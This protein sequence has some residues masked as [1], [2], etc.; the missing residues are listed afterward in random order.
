[1]S[2]VFYVATC[3]VCGEPCQGYEFRGR[4]RVEM[5]MHHGCRLDADTMC[6]S[7]I[8]EVIVDLVSLTATARRLP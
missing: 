7:T 2:Y 8:V 5:E 3:P 6:V 1:M 4:F